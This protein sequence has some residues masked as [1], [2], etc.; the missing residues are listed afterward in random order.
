PGVLRQGLQ[1]LE[2]LQGRVEFRNL[3]LPDRSKFVHRSLA[4]ACR[5]RSDG[6]SGGLVD[7]RS[8]AR[9]CAPGASHDSPW[10][11]APKD[12]AGKGTCRQTRRSAAAATREASRG[13][14]TA[15]VG[16]NGIRRSCAGAQHPKGY[17]DVTAVSCPRQ[18]AENSEGILRLGGG[19]CGPTRKLRWARISTKMARR[20]V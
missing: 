12:R 18:H 14:S 1:K 13:S 5:R 8:G 4:A 16:R 20:C 17:G 11:R 7:R 2:L 15:R 6:A 3:A 9:G 10:A 19:G